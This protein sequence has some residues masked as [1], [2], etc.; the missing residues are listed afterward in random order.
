MINTKV[1]KN[2]LVNQTKELCYKRSYFKA[3]NHKRFFNES[4]CKSVNYLDRWSVYKQASL[5]LDLVQR[6]TEEGEET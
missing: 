5:Y 6:Q 1:E 4:Q 2:I 3:G